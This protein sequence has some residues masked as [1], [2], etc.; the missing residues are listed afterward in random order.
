M[1][2]HHLIDILDALWTMLS[3]FFSFNSI[4]SSDWLIL[5]TV[6]LVRA[7]VT[8]ENSIVAPLKIMNTF[9]FKYCTIARHKVWLIWGLLHWALYIVL[10]I[11]Y[12]Y[13]HCIVQLHRHLIIIYFV[14]HVQPF[15]FLFAVEKYV[16]ICNSFVKMSRI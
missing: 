12:I 10:D 7:F 4:Y 2:S 8:L 16:Y 9:L 1:F 5:F 6:Y 11:F 14:I 3:N 13:L 15:P